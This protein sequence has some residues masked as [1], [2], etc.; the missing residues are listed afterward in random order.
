MIFIFILFIILESIKLN[1]QYENCIQEIEDN[2]K[3]Y[4]AQAPFRIKRHTRVCM[5]IY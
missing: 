3:I 2:L 4:L 1:P 5:F